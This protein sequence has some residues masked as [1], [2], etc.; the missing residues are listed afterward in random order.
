VP[1]LTIVALAR[2]HAGH[3]RLLP[4]T[5][6]Q[7]A[8]HHARIAIEVCGVCGSDVALRQGRLRLLHG[9]P[10]PLWLGHEYA[11]TVADVGDAVDAE[12]LGARVCAEPSVGCGG[13]EQCQQGAPNRC[14]E[15]RYEG[16]GFAPFLDVDASRLHR[17]PDAL[18][19]ELGAFG[20]PLACV[21]HALTERVPVPTAA[22]CMVVG[23]G[24][25]GIL[26][27]LVVRALGAQP[28]VLGRRSSTTRLAVARA[29][30]LE[31]VILEGDVT[32]P[33]AGGGSPR[34]GAVDTVTCA[35]IVVGC[36]GDAATLDLGTARL[37]P[38]GT[39]VEL[40]MPSAAGSVDVERLVRR[41]VT[42]VGSLGH[43]PTAWRRA[44]ALLADATVPGAALARMVTARHPLQQWR[45]A[46]DDAADRAHVKVLIWPGERT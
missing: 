19:L 5:L 6:P 21:V 33:V 11:G 31:T 40:G 12:W 28:V 24:P 10:A 13:C 14:L 2:D 32:N 9:A 15:R 4:R 18:P 3:V 1:G 36:T 41:E 16:G 22:R 35:D 43:T 26:A 34:I 17:L 46:F 38:G 44:Q 25:L 45:D 39:Y 37:A 8:P 30:G 7:L 42:V 23:P 27:A 20:E 29:L